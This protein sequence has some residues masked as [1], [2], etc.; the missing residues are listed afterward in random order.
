MSSAESSPPRVWIEKTQQEGRSYKQAGEL[1]LGEALIAP[2]KDKGG[3]RRYETLREAEVGD[4][5]LHLVQEQY[6]IVALSVIDSELQE[7]FEG[8]PGNDWSEEQRAAGGYRRDL[9]S[10]AAIEPH[11][12]IYE[13][14]LSNDE[15]AAELKQIRAETDSKI[16]YTKNLQLN[17]GHYFTECP[18]ELVEI[19]AKESPYLKDLLDEHGYPINGGSSRYD[20]I[21][22]ATATVREQ[23]TDNAD[24]NWLGTIIAAERIEHWT[25]VLRRND[26]VANQIDPSDVDVYERLFELYTEHSDHLATKAEQLGVSQIKN[27]ELTPGEV[28]FV[29][30]IRDLQHRADLTPNF[31]H[32]KMAQLLDERFRQPPLSAPESPPRRHTTIARQLSRAKQLVFHGP[33]GTGKTYTARRF[34]RWWLTEESTAPTE[35]QLE[36]VTFHPSF[37]YEGT[38]RLT[39][40]V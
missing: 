1:A 30:L 32:V 12:H 13:D 17:Q 4:L 19:L 27:A 14:V 8:P 6:Q 20:G 21:T 5:V 9:R 38:A 39:L 18:R 35:D 22:E 26:L 23:L 24:G 34:A 29:V 3:H 15:Y 2:S 31:N 28:L 7:D 25:T 10:K 16:L 33:P 36:V 11:I 40:S 37:T